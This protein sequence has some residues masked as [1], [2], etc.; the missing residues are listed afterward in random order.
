M[1]STPCLLGV[2]T[3]AT[4][5]STMY[6]QVSVSHFLPQDSPTSTRGRSTGSSTTSSSEWSRATRAP[7]SRTSWAASWRPS[8][9]PGRRPTMATR[10]WWSSWTTRRTRWRPSPSSSPA[11]WRCACWCWSTLW[12]SSRGRV[13]HAT[14]CTANAPCRNGSET[15]WG[16]VRRWGGTRHRGKQDGG[17][18]F[19]RG[20]QWALDN[21]RENTQPRLLLLGH[22]I[23]SI[24]P[25][26]TK[27][28]PRT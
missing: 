22:L 13:R 27:G 8:T 25:L 24:R 20:G 15:S 18:H 10:T 7:S 28:D 17:P 19:H 14:Y 26:Q 21:F 23:P 3:C 4:D 6:L 5:S 11:C 12:C 16:K 1:A 9:P 2:V